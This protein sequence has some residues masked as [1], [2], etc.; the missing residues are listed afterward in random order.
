MLKHLAK[1]W[2][3][4]TVLGALLRRKLPSS[5]STSSAA[6]RIGGAG[7]ERSDM[8]AAKKKLADLKKEASQLDEAFQ[9]KVRAIPART[10]NDQ[11]KLTKH[12]LPCRKGELELETLDV[13]W[14]P[15][16]VQPNGDRSL[17][18]RIDSRVGQTTVDTK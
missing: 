3:V 6:K 1:R 2:G 10:P 15:M 4:E 13:V 5:T 16:A 7:K 9:S 11:I 17:L 14:V 8:V 12:L 18:S